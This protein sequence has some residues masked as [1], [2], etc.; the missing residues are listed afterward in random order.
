MCERAWGLSSLLPALLCLAL[1]GLASANDRPSV[2]AGAILQQQ[3]QIRS[4]A[5]AGRGSFKDLDPAKRADL[6]A[7]QDRV[8]ELLAG[9]AA[10]GELA[11]ADQVALAT[12]LDAIQAIVIH[13]E[14]ERKVCVPQK[15]IGS[16]RPVISCRT[17]AE[18]RAAREDSR[19]GIDRRNL[20]H[21]IVLRNNDCAASPDACSRP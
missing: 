10:T 19:L 8:A 16:H 12:E 13:A 20:E 1:A 18:R 14:D 15:R 2:A 17:V 11:D 9:I 4:D 3:Q 7:R 6:F 5:A 21:E